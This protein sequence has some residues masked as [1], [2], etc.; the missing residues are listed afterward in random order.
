MVSGA[1]WTD[2]H[3]NF[4]KAGVI[5]HP[6]ERLLSFQIW[7]SGS[8]GSS[9]SWG[10]WMDGGIDAQACALKP[11]HVPHLSCSETGAAIVGITQGPLGGLI[12]KLCNTRLRFVLFTLGSH[13]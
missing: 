5:S 7:I 4:V 9:R 11:L 2:S 8:G 3:L 13:G 1:A 10:G 12:W 6:E